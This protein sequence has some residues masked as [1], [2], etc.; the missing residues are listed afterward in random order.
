MRRTLER[1]TGRRVNARIEP[2]ELLKILAGVQN[3]N[4][5]VPEVAA[6][7]EICLSPRK[8][9]LLTKGLNGKS[10]AFPV[11]G[12]SLADV[13]VACVRLRRLDAE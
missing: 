7:G 4:A 10:A 13:T 2:L 6:F 11:E 3:E 9:W 12:G 8:V 1:G 5:A